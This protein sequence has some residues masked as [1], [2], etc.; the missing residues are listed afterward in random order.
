MRR[1]WIAA[2]VVAGSAHLSGAVLADDKLVLPPEVTPA[3]RAACEIDVRR[4]CIGENPTVAKVR[5]C[6]EQRFSELSM[7]CR[8]QIAVAGLTPRSVRGRQ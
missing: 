1:A 8:M 3:L 2:A 4:L 6:V 7:R 5:R